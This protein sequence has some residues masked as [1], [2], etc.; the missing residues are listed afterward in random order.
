MG[1]RVLVLGA[2]LQGRAVVEDLVK[3]SGVDEVIV[4]DA[5]P[6]ALK[7]PWPASDVTRV[8]AVHLDAADHNAVAKLA[9]C[10][11]SC[12]V[13]MLPKRFEAIAA[14][15]A[16]EAGCHLVS[17]NYGQALEALNDR[18]TER[19]VTIMPESGL[20]PG[21][22]FVM[23]A[24]AISMFDELDTLISYGTG[25]P[26]PECRDS[27]PIQYKVSWTLAG[28]LG[29]YRRPGR[30]LIDGEERE[31]SPDEIFQPR[32][33]H[34]VVHPDCGPLEAYVNGDAVRCARLFCILGSVR[35]TARFS[36]R[37][38]GHCAFWS[39][40]G[41]LGLLD[42]TPLAGTDMSPREFLRRWLEPRLQY[43]DDERDMIILRLDVAGRRGG[44]RKARRWEVV[45]YRDMTT[46]LMAMNRTVGYPASIVAQMIMRGE[47]THRGVCSP[48]RDVPPEP[49][50]A[51]LAE[52]GISVTEE[53]VDPDD[54][55]WPPSPGV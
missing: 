18:A 4:A 23:A 8:T 43:A 48:A 46:G 40:V 3:R 14:G 25:I 29:A 47:V 11:L 22:D 44:S 5:R 1:D 27:S 34:E 21:I 30:V 24:R 49:F 26:A 37:W 51:A 17:T 19:G 15:A 45:D 33:T 7:W 16:L 53:E 55:P 41:G 6:E 38:P 39:R 35:N 20:D 12:I 10:G 31:L 36:L 52:R 42:D 32:W 13:N 50:L 28:V 54:C 2:G 9:A